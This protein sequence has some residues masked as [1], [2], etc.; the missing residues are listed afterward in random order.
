MNRLA[1]D[2]QGERDE[3]PLAA[4]RRRIGPESERTGFRK[5]V[6]ELEKTV[7]EFRMDVIEEGEVLRDDDQ[8]HESVVDELELADRIR[9]GRGRHDETEQGGPIGDGR[10][11][12]CLHLDARDSRPRCKLSG[13]RVVR[14]VTAVFRAIGTSS[15][16]E[17]TLQLIG[18]TEGQIFLA[19]GGGASRLV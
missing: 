15:P 6:G 4:F 16:H 7:P 13:G 9:V 18:T 2:P 8:V 11:G 5:R 10:G 3:C 1:L 12:F 19:P 17:S 14:P